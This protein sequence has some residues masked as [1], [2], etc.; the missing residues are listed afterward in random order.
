VTSNPRSTGASGSPH[1]GSAGPVGRLPFRVRVRGVGGRV[2]CRATCGVLR[3]VGRLVSIGL[4]PILTSRSTR[5]PIVALTIDDGPDPTTTPPLLEVLRRHDAR[6]TFFLIGERAVA[7]DELVRAVASAGHELGNHLW[8]D[9]PSVRLPPDQFRRE[10]L[11]VDRLLRAH[12]DVSLFRP[13]SGWSTRRMLRDAALRGYRCVLG[14]PWLL[15]TQYDQDPAAQG[16]RLGSRAHA[17]AIVVLHEGPPDRQAVAVAA[18]ALLETLAQRGLR[19]VTV[20]EVFSVQPGS[21]RWFPRSCS[22]RDGEPGPPRRRLEPP[23]RLVWAQ[24]VGRLRRP[25]GELTRHPRG[26]VDGGRI[27]DLPRRISDST[28]AVRRRCG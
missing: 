19:A 28:A 15:V 12:G 24:V 13:G 18:D 20:R 8:Q 2:A 4:P 3:G 17:G 9:R 14:S 21:R 11:K 5:D 10:L 23:V 16:R 25:G 6:A 7:H 27:E 1:T 26:G 22:C